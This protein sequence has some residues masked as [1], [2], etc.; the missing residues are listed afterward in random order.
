MARDNQRRQRVILTDRITQADTA[1]DGPKLE[2]NPFRPVLHMQSKC[3]RKIECE[4][5][6]ACRDANIHDAKQ[7][8][9]PA[10]LDPC[11]ATAIPGVDQPQHGSC[12]L[13]QLEVRTI[14]PQPDGFRTKLHHP[15]AILRPNT[16][17]LGSD[18]EAAHT[19]RQTGIKLIH[20]CRL[21]LHT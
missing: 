8:F 10:N 4:I 12:P 11:R 1:W 21:W 5:R 3:V 13:K 20:A 9:T 14:K 6:P 17:R 7:G 16:I 15:Q 2:F 18:L 19:S